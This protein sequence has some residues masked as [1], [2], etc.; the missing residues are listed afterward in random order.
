M[1]GRCKRRP[2]G[3]HYRTITQ[4]RVL[5]T[6]QQQLGYYLTPGPTPTFPTIA[7]A[8][9]GLLQK[10]WQSWVSYGDAKNPKVNP[11][12]EVE[13]QLGQIEEVQRW[14]EDDCPDLG[15]RVV[16]IIATQPQTSISVGSLGEHKKARKPTPDFNLEQLRGGRWAKA[17]AVI[18]HTGLTADDSIGIVAFEMAKWLWW[19]EL[20]DLPEDDRKV[21][22]VD[23]LRRFVQEKHNNH[24]TRWTE[25][26][27]EEV[28]GQIARCVKRAMVLNEPQNF[29][30]HG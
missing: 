24:I 19:V 15:R 21:R 7:R 2:F 1:P 10:Q 28:F 13:Q 3:E 12:D 22:I 16:P 5:E 18:A 30:T 25:G 14:I 8:L 26:Q 6:W 27:H 17:L 20:Y 9:L 11:T 4:D 29:G 23:L